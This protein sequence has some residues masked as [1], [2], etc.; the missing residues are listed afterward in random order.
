MAHTRVVSA[1]CARQRLALL[2][3]VGLIR[4][5]ALPPPED[6]ATHMTHE[7][8]EAII[9]LTRDLEEAWR[10]IDQADPS[11]GVSPSP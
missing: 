2:K 7:V 8:Q 11:A 9:G 10:V 4:E 5:V 3:E 6:H 1:G